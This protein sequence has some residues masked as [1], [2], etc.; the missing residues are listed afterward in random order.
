MTPLRHSEES[1]TDVAPKP[2]AFQL[3]TA[4]VLGGTPNQCFYAACHGRRAN[5]TLRS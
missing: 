1:V 2:A 4:T 5:L 3:A